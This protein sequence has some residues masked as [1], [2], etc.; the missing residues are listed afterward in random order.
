MNRGIQSNCTT[1]I[2]RR[3]SKQSNTGWCF[4]VGTLNVEHPVARLFAGHLQGLRF[5]ARMDTA[6]PSAACVCNG[7]THCSLLGH[8][9]FLVSSNDPVGRPNFR[10]LFAADA[11][12]SGNRSA[13]LVDSGRFM[14]IGSASKLFYLWGFWFLQTVFRFLLYFRQQNCRPDRKFLWFLRLIMKFRVF[15]LLW[16]FWVLAC[17]SHVRKSWPWFRSSQGFHCNEPWKRKLC[18]THYTEEQDKCCGK[19]ALGVRKNFV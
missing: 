5:Y 16:N 10:R 2:F 12:A 1:W 4:P 7:V 14:W 17:S 3:S 19:R 6:R 18:I 11:N 13:S 15:A 8:S 9:P